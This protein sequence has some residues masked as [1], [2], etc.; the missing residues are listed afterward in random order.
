MAFPLRDGRST[1]DG[2]TLAIGWRQ[3]LP[4]G[5]PV[6]HPAKNAEVIGEG[7]RELVRLTDS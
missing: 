2:V 6:R 7:M 4:P 3:R 5:D 1:G